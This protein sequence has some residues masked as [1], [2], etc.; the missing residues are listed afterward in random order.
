MQGKKEVAPVQGKPKYPRKLRAAAEK[1]QFRQSEVGTTDSARRMKAERPL[2]VA[3]VHDAGEKEVAPVQ[4][5]SSPGAG[6]APVRGERDVVSKKIVQFTF[7]M[8]G[9]SK[10]WV[11]VCYFWVLHD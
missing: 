9:K 5:K 2:C 3:P 4:G 6:E 7:F 8:S 11:L 10:G 1:E